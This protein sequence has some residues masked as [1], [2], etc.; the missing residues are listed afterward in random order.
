MYATNP[1]KWA[2]M[3]L[4]RFWDAK[5]VSIVSLIEGKHTTILYQVK[6]MNLRVYANFY[7]FI[8]NFVF[9]FYNIW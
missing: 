7:Y 6:R 8:T 1:L 3:F 9:S 5:P 2:L 4:K